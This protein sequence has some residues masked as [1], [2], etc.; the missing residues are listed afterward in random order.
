[1]SPT[2]LWQRKLVDG[3]EVEAC[4]WHDADLAEATVE[5]SVRAAHS[6]DT[7]AVSLANAIKSALDERGAIPI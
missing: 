3:A 4:L 1:M 2:K 6:E 5:L 7:L